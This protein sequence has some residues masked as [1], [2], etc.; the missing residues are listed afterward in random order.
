[1]GW[2]GLADGILG[3]RVLVYGVWGLWGVVTKRERDLAFMEVAA[4]GN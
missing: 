3:G 4:K 2:G 1:M